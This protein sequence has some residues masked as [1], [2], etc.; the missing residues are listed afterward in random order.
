MSGLSIPQIEYFKQRLLEQR[1]ELLALADSA[2]QASEVVELDQ[3]RQGRLSRMD[4]LQGQAMSKAMQQ[5][6]EFQLKQIDHALK[7]IED[8]EY[9]YCLRCDEQIASQRLEYD[10]AVRLCIN[11]AE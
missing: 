9:G 7:R 1:Q 10:P 2:N 3:T 5:R 4:A 6:R 8:D 11:C